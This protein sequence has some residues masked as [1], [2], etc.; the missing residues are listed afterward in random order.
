M[1][2]LLRI[3]YKLL[4]NDRGKFFALLVGIT[5]AVFLMIMMTS[6]FAGIMR[7]SSATV[8][9][10]GAKV[11]VMDPSVE[12]VLSSIPMP[13]YVLDGVRSIPGVKYAVPLFSGTGLAKLASGGYQAVTV[14]GL[15]DNSLLGRPEML[16]GNIA[17]IYAGDGVIV[18]RDAEYGKL[19]RPKL[20]ATF[21]LNDR[22]A[23]VV[24][25]G[26]LPESGLFGLP[27]IYTTFSRA[28]EYVPS[29]RFTISYVLVEPVSDAAIPSIEEA[30]RKLGYTART[31]REFQE[32][33]AN[34][35]KYRTGIGTNILLMTAISFLVGLSISGQAFYAFVLENLD[36]FG[37]LKAIGA[38]SH[39]LVYMILFEVGITSFAGY[40]L[41]IGLCALLIAIARARLASYASIITFGNLG[42]AFVMVL[43]IAA[44]SSYLG[45]RRVLRIEPFEVFRA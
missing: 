26:K 18:I 41:G 14:I 30:V 35:Y 20:G 22:R 8:T 19:G 10:T 13:D 45:I 17:D 15:D 31:E 44:V 12:N 38:K 25:L 39:Q 3:A 27:T 9:N 32:T 1:T 37:A 11:W 5:F 24:G 40:G 7:K 33:I 6:A 2:G 36:R 21:E 16:Q 4:V 23:V 29:A 43:V 28:T 42:L 34:F